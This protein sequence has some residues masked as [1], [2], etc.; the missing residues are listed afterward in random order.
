MTMGVTAMMVMMTIDAKTSR[1][2][3]EKTR[4]F[5]SLFDLRSSAQYLVIW[6]MINIFEYYN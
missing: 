1:T 3:V 5:M 4:T 2:I 6:S